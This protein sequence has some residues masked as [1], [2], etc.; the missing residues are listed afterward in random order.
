MVCRVVEENVPAKEAVDPA[1]LPAVLIVWPASLAVVEVDGEVVTVRLALETP[2]EVAGDQDPVVVA[3]VVLAVVEGELM[4]LLVATRMV[5]LAGPILSLVTL[6]AAM[7][8]VGSLSSL[9]R[10]RLLRPTRRRF[11][12]AR[13]LLKKRE[14]MRRARERERERLSPRSTERKLLR[15]LDGAGEA[16]WLRHLPEH[17]GRVFRSQRHRGLVWDCARL[18]LA[19]SG[20]RGHLILVPFEKRG[21]LRNC[22]CEPL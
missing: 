6:V 21:L 11:I 14:K 19:L 16:R 7:V 22:F 1:V 2:L 12:K 8:V 13:L 18:C 15:K 20:F 9:R 4:M 10:P 3:V 5:K 17:W